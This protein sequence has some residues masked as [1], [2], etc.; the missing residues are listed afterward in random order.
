MVTRGAFRNIFIL[1]TVS[2]SFFPWK[3][4]REQG[5]NSDSRYNFPEKNLENYSN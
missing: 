5:L 4:Y 2:S 1:K 3:K